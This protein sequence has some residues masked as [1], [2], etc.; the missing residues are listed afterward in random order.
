MI[1]VKSQDQQTLVI[2]ALKRGQQ[3]GSLT[4]NN[5]SLTCFPRE[6]CQIDDIRFD[7]SKWWEI[8]PITKIDLA[9][10]QITEISPQVSNLQDLTLLRMGSNSLES[11]PAELFLIQT[12]K[13][14]DFSNNKIKFFPMKL[15]DC[16]SLVE[17]NLQNNLIESLPDNWKLKNLEIL[18]LS[19]NKINKF[20]ITKGDLCKLKRLDISNNNI[21]LIAGE[22]DSLTD[23]EFLGLSKN[24]LVNIDSN[25]F[26]PLKNLKLLDLKENR[27]LEFSSFPIS[28][29]I[30]SVFLAYNQLTSVQGFENSPN[31]TIL[32]IKNNKITTLHRSIYTLKKLKTL[33]LMNNDLTDIPSE[34]GFLT[35]LVRINIEGNP[36]KCI[37]STIKSGGT[38]ALKK[39]LRE[40]NV[41]EGD[42]KKMVEEFE[43]VLPIDVYDQYIKDF[44]ISGKE[45]SVL[46]QGIKEI[47]DKFCKLNLILLD[48]S[49]NEI[50]DINKN[51]ENLKDLVKLRLNNNKLENFPSQILI[52]F[53][54]L[55][56]L[57][58]RGNKLSSIFE[59]IPPDQGNRFFPRLK[60]VDLT[61]N[62]LEKIPN[63]LTYIP[64]LRMLAI[65]YNKISDMNVL[66]DDN[67]VNLEILDI[68][69]NK[70][71]IISEEI[72]KL[73]KL[74]HFN[75]ENNSITKEEI[76]KALM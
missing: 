43:K 34:I 60:S 17:V 31:L 2:N 14:I 67:M 38:E 46:S 20:S 47:P 76:L 48:L 29:K 56:E 69:N 73:R 71:E 55:E 1:D 9:F 27:L 24:K 54:N 22:M 68:S 28:I 5:L 44:L 21:S 45:L 70:L 16:C 50:C 58:L 12:L 62:R 35:Q 10:N 33:D 42:T 26:K 25:I 7:Q 23:L 72:I 39:Y 41:H 61:Q 8:N 75:V 49:K 32:D 65:A 57:E 18:N 11:I 51:L 36:L 30:D 63:I 13:S 3:S 19:G 64:T 37:R 6:I 52:N 4:M 15:V 40:R 74:E 66:L 59:G 53:T